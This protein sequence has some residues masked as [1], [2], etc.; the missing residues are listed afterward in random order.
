VA[1]LLS[2]GERTVDRH[3]VCAKEWLFR[4]VRAQM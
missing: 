1:E 4:K 2:I 3:W